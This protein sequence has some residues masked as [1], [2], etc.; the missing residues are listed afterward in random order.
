MHFYV[1]HYDMTV[2][3]HMRPDSARR[4]LVSLPEPFELPYEAT[5]V[6]PFVSRPVKHELYMMLLETTKSLL[7]D[8]EKELQQRDNAV[9]APCFCVIVILCICAERTQ[10]DT[11]RNII[12]A[13]QKH[14]AESTAS[15]RTGI[16]HCRKLE[17]YLMSRCVNMFHEFR[18]SRQPK[19]DKKPQRGFNPLR[20]G[21]D[22]SIGEG[23]D[24]ATVALIIEVQRLLTEFGR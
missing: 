10:I 17:D 14:G 23:L 24:Q 18:R 21:L 4:A 3:L 20:D 16:D 5:L 22:I 11:D 12:Y 7:A 2:E 6:S 9:W 1:M 15:R 19:G 13:I 8:L